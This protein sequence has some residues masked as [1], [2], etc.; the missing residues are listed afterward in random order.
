MIFRP[1]LI[2]LLLLWGCSDSNEEASPSFE[3]KEPSPNFQPKEASPDFEPVKSAPKFEMNPQFLTLPKGAPSIGASHGDIAV[4]PNGDVYVSVEGGDHPGVQVYSA[5]GRYLQNVP[6][7]PND[8]HGFTIAMAPDGRPNIFGVSLG[9]QRVIQMTLDGEI[10][11][12][13]SASSFPDQYKTTKEG[14]QALSL[15][16]IAVG[17]NGEI[18]VVDGYGRDFIHRFDMNGD[19]LD[20][21]GGRDEP[22][23][24]KNCHQIGLDTRFD[25]VRILCTD[26]HN[27][28]LVQ[29]ELDGRVI[30]VF[31][32][33]LLFPSALAV[34]DD[35]LAIAE[36]DGRVTILDMEGKTLATIGANEDPDKRRTSMVP[37]DEW[38]PNLF[39]APHGIAF[40]ANGDLFV[41][42]W[43]RWGRVTRLKRDR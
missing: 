12:D 15:T 16:G 2:L 41:A 7:A 14:K 11:L 30:G 28:R 9:G 42:E 26:R 24:F 1:A 34:F 27:G 43:S 8:F 35:E 33:G 17:P 5:E 22:W 6:N 4:A 10:V 36:L 18:Y 29:M 19:Y 32:E 20:T 40:D 39:Y 3:T 37:P 31:A 13:I 25:P 21:F 23:N 38:K